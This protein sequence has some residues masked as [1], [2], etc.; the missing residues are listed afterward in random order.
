MPQRI[1]Y[2]LRSALNSPFADTSCP[3]CDSSATR[4]LRKKYLVTRLYQ[5]DGCGL[6]FRTPKDTQEFAEAF[7]TH[8]YSTDFSSLQPDDAELDT[9]LHGECSVAECGGNYTGYIRVLKSLQISPND[10][11]VD[12]GAGWGFGSWQMLRA[13]YRVYAYDLSLPRIRYAI[14]K[15]GV[16]GTHRREELPTAVQCVIT[17]HVL[18]HLID[19]K[20]LWIDAS[21]I[22]RICLEITFPY[23]NVLAYTGC[24]GRRRCNNDTLR[25]SEDTSGRAGE[26]VVGGGRESGDR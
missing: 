11:I 21:R 19:P 2:F 25:G 13:G 7:Y 26:T 9:F 20:Q 3:G 5:C 12:Y 4:Q 17:A 6:R 23:W 16:T 10:V 15:L 1:A 24:G 22:L 18:E 8:L 14:D